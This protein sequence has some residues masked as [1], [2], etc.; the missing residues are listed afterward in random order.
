[1]RFM[2]I[3]DLTIRRKSKKHKAKSFTMSYEQYREKLSKL[4]CKEPKIHAFGATFII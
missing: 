3:Q 1:M 2:D 4:H